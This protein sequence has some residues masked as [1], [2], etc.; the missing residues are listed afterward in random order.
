ML[1]LDVVLLA[2]ASESDGAHLI[3]GLILFFPGP[4]GA[5]GLQVRGLAAFREGHLEREG[6]NGVARLEA[7]RSIRLILDANVVN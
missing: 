3:H 7:L 5:S 4:L 1:T 6:A 2:R